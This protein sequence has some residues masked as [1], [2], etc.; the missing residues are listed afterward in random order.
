LR[1]VPGSTPRPILTVL[2]SVIILYS[3]RMVITP[4]FR[5]DLHTVFKISFSTPEDRMQAIS[6]ILHSQSG[7]RILS[8][9]YYVDVGQRSYGYKIRIVSKDDIPGG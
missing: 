2:V 8:V 7:V 6:E 3:F 4:S 5:H 1:S 9:N